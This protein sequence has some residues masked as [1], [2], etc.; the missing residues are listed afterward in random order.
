MDIYEHPQTNIHPNKHNILKTKRTILHPKKLNKFFFIKTPKNN[1]Y[2]SP[3]NQNIHLNL[4]YPSIQLQISL[5]TL[6]AKISLPT[7]RP[8]YIILNSIPKENLKKFHMEFFEDNSNQINELTQLLR[9]NNHMREEKWQMTF[10][11]LNIL[12][13]N[14]TTIDQETCSAPSIPTLNIH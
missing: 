6:I 1:Q 5:N 13:T 8:S 11:S 12:I 4:N 9:N 14:I 3:T 2:T 7:P 10:T